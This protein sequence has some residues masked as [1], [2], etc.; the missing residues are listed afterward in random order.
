VEK[1]VRRTFDPS[2]PDR[3][4]PKVR[5]TRRELQQPKKQPDLD[6]P[7][8]STSRPKASFRQA[9]PESGGQ[10]RSPTDVWLASRTARLLFDEFRRVRLLSVGHLEAVIG[11]VAMLAVIETFDLFFR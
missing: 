4:G 2:K 9:E 11:F 5:R 7:G 10:A 3:D 1:R 8:G 6:V